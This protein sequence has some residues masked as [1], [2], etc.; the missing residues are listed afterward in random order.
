LFF[1]P[2]AS[3]TSIFTPRDLY[4]CYASCASQRKPCTTC[5]PSRSQT[6]PQTSAS[7]LL[8]REPL[9]RVHCRFVE[10]IRERLIDDV[11]EVAGKNGHGRQVRRLKQGFVL[12][13]P[14]MDETGGDDWTRGW[15]QHALRFVLPPYSLG[16]TT[17]SNNTAHL[18]MAILTCRS[19]KID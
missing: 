15:E 8:P 1:T 2:P 10:A 9:R 5:P 19:R 4:P 18:F 11:C 13:R 12:G 3:E 14:G 7:C 16:F 17:H 6:R